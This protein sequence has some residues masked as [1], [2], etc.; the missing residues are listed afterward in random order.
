MIKSCVLLNFIF[1]ACVLSGNFGFSQP[2]PD[3]TL[4]TN[5]VTCLC[6]NATVGDTGTLNINGVDKTFTKRTRAQLDALIAADISDPEIALTCTSGITDMSLLFHQTFTFNQ[7]I[8]SWDVSSV[9]NMSGI[10][11][12]SYVF[13]Q[14]LNNWDMSNVTNMSLMFYEAD[15]FNQ[16]LNNWNT[17]NV[18]NMSNMFYGANYFNQPINNWDTSNV[19]NTTLMFRSTN[20]NQPLSNW[21]V[22]NV[23][24]MKLMFSLAQNFNQPLNNWDV[25]NVTN[26]EG[27]FD[28]AENFNQPLDNWDVSNVDNME[29]MFYAAENFNQPLNNWDVSSVTNMRF[30][31]AD[32]LIFNQSLRDWDVSNVTDM[33]FMFY[34]AVSFNQDITDWCVQQFPSE[35][36]NFSS[37]S[38]LVSSFMPNWGSTCSL[39]VADQDFLNFYFYPNPVSTKIN[40]DW[41]QTSIKNDIQINIYDLSGKIVFSKDYK[42]PPN[43]LDV[44]FLSDGK[45]IFKAES[46]EYILTKRLI[47][48]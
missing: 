20:F 8:S 37:G 34:N 14:P 9:T 32:C 16:P 46:N 28:R 15:N 3:F 42:L 6:P 40:L 10:F 19:T 7:D 25:S 48:K 4:A 33:I 1:L 21:D 41:S 29:S 35:P 12:G 47:K 24:N 17:S 36:H 26:M 43:Q 23:T 31:F 30:M 45:Y 5:G 18:T 38:P 39:G 2:N 22:S 27:L 44:K 11:W 13:N